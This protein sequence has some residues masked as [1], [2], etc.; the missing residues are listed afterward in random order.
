MESTYSSHLRFMKRILLITLCFIS[1]EGFSQFNS[2][3][4]VS[5]IYH[6]GNAPITLRLELINYPKDS[7]GSYQMTISDFSW[8]ENDTLYTNCYSEMEIY[9]RLKLTDSVSIVKDGYYNEIFGEPYYFN[10][11]KDSLIF[12]F[13][14]PGNFDGDCECYFLP[15]RLPVKNNFDTTLTLY[16][17]TNMKYVQYIDEAKASIMQSDPMPGGYQP[18]RIN[19][20]AFYIQYDKG[21][22]YSGAKIMKKFSVKKIA[23]S[24]F[25]F[26]EPYK[27]YY[28]KDK[29][30]I[31][32][33]ELQKL[34]K[35]DLEKFSIKENFLQ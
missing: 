35:V 5:S 30:S 8:E 32:G 33:Q 26:I 11:D 18:T 10:T 34:K 1:V 17:D 28:Y 21:K 6:S 19:L 27:N 22:I 3:Y 16:P 20:N 4:P 15:I 31:F 24:N 9:L 13:I 7:K 2:I 23:N 25:L 29:T 12:N 14:Y